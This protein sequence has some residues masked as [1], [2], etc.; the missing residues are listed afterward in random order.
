VQKTILSTALILTFGA[1]VA[2]SE[3]KYDPVKAV[4]Y[5][6]EHTYKKCTGNYRNYKPESGVYSCPSYWNTTKYLDVDDYDGGS[7][8]G[9]NCIGFVSECLVAGGIP[10]DSQWHYPTDAWNSIKRFLGR[11]FY[12]ADLSEYNTH[13]NPYTRPKPVWADLHPVMLDYTQAKVGDIAFL[14]KSGK[15]LFHHAVIV[16]KSYKNG[17]FAYTGHTTDVVDE[18]VCYPDPHSWKILHFNPEPIIWTTRHLKVGKGDYNY[19]TGK[20]NKNVTS[21]SNKFDREYIDFLHSSSNK[22]TKVYK[23]VRDDFDIDE[24]VRIVLISRK[25]IHINIK[26]ETF[27]DIKKPAFTIYHKNSSGQRVIDF[28]SSSNKDSVEEY[29]E[30]RYTYKDFTFKSYI[31]YYVAVR[32]DSNQKNSLYLFYVKDI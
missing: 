5:A 7:G 9:T 6:K 12:D 8:Y 14:R 1:T 30:Y 21:K 31:D 29:D 11:I 13:A 32:D 27:V 4:Q 24:D 2:N 25:N 26:N 10:T 3:I 28:E 15:N 18:D 19:L 22:T 20:P 16:T 17:C 23:I